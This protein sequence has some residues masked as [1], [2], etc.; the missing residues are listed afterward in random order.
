MKG[1]MCVDI[2]GSGIQTSCSVIAT[3]KE[4]SAM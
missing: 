4:G 2:D 1:V 3:A